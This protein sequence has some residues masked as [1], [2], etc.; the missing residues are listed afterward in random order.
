M[1][2]IGSGEA[3][4]ATA[5]GRWIELHE[6]DFFG[7]MALLERRRH[8]HDVIA[9]TACRIYVLDGEGLARL[10]RRHPEI[11]R[12]IRK[13]AMERERENES[14][15]TAREDTERQGAHPQQ[16]GSAGVR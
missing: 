13:V 7:E 8:K 14:G 11:V 1:Y 15:A 2:L 9:K 5:P 6:G 4:A 3:M 10:S 16:A 12:H